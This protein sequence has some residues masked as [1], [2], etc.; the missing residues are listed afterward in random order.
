MT[1]GKNPKDSKFRMKS[2]VTFPFRSC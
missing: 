2:F 1:F